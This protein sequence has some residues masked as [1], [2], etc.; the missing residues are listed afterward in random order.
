M[1]HNYHYTHVGIALVEACSVD[2]LAV[3]IGSIHG[4]VFT[5]LESFKP[6]TSEFDGSDDD[7]ITYFRQI[8]AF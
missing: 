4:T 7:K 2:I 5:W 6:G 3:G 1:G 8:E